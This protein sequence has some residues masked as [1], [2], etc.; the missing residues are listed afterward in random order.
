MLVMA[1]IIRDVKP[2]KQMKKQQ[3]DSMEDYL[4]RIAILGGDKGIVRITQ[5]S[6]TMGVKKSSVTAAI[7]KLLKLG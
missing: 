1:N 7:N 6:R 5:L 4:E 2:V 3:T